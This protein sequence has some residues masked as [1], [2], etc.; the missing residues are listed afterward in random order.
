MKLFCGTRI[1]AK[2]FQVETTRGKIP[3][4]RIRNPWGNAQ[5]WN[6]D[7]SDESDLWS[8]VSDRQKQDM[9]LVLAHDG[10]FWLV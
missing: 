5:E 6:G 1:S 10:E 7:W 3:L 2:S 8:C 4:L 9:N